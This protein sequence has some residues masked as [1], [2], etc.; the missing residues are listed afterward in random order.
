MAGLS[1]SERLYRLVGLEAFLAGLALAA[2][3]VAGGGVFLV[4]AVGLAG[5]SIALVVTA[6]A[7]LGVG[8]WAGAEEA[9]DVEPPLRTR[10]LGAAATLAAPGLVASAI[11]SFP[12]LGQGAPIRMLALLVLLAAPA[13]T[14]GVLLPTLLGWA[15]R[16]AELL[17]EGD[18]EPSVWQP[19]GSVIG[20]VIA[21]LAFGTALVGLV[22]VPAIGAGPALLGTAAALVLPTLVAEPS[23]GAPQERLIF[24]TESPLSRIRVVEIVYPGQRQPERRLYVNDEEESGEQIRSGAPTLAYIAAAEQWLAQVA[25]PGDSYYFLGG[26]AQTLPRRTRERDPK[27]AI[28]VVELDPEVTRTA[29]RFFGIRRD[30][31]ITTVHGDARAFL[32][33]D[34]TDTVDRIYL[35]VYAG[36]ETL[37]HALVTR[38]AFARMSL[39]LR[40]GG[41]LTLNAIGTTVGPGARRL[42]SLIRTVSDV[43][44]AVTVLTHLGP[45]F[46]DRQN[47]LIAAALDPDA[48]LPTS[49]GIFQSWDRSEWPDSSDTI[50]FRDLYSES[51]PAPSVTHEAAERSSGA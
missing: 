29:Y 17:D 39:L 37:P 49:T 28:T 23:A 34:A 13:Y 22:L 46:P 5:A 50:V 36:Q 33:D 27:A 2:V 40:P 35:D 7:A 20:G 1:P 16:Q 42:W 8:I 21:G 6:V 32:Q 24:G 30:H 48:R 3:A 47:V 26:G 41:T 18:F 38:E 31:G 4:D 10:W 15:E 45:D 25:K 43:F 51:R 12:A 11:R 44:P 14:L 9:A 19:L